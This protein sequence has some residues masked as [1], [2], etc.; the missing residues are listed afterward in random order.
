MMMGTSGQ[1]HWELIRKIDPIE[2]D[3]IDV[4]TVEFLDPTEHLDFGET[5]AGGVG[6][7]AGICVCPS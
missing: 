2:A 6:G 3:G 1:Q 7:S 5:E 4:D